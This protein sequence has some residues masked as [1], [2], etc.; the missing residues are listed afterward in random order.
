MECLKDLQTVYATV[1][2]QKTAHE[3]SVAHCY[4][5]CNFE[6]SKKVSVNQKVTKQM[7]GSSFSILLVD[8]YQPESK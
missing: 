3:A 5:I 1:T 2:N 4:L 7:R 6:H 8:V